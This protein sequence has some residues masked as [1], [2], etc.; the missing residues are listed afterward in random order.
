MSNVINNSVSALIA[1]QRAI[2]VASQN[3][4]NA[5]TDGYVRQRID[6]STQFA[7][8][9]R[10][11]L[12]TGGVKIDGVRR[13]VN[14]FLI[15]QARTAAAGAGRAEVMAEQASAVSALLSSTAI[16]PDDALQDLK[17]AFNA[18]ATEPGSTRARDTLLTEIDS[19][20]DKFQTVDTRL[21]ALD[22]GINDRL[23]NEADEVNLLLSQVAT[24]NDKLF[25]SNITTGASPSH[26]LDERDRLLDKLSFKLGITVTTVANDSVTVKTQDGK[27]LVQG[28][29]A[30]SLS[31]ISGLHDPT[32]MRVSLLSADGV[33]FD[34]TQQLAGGMLGGLIDSRSQVTTLVR[35][36]LGRVAV[37][38]SQALNAQ[39]RAGAD[40]DGLTGAAGSDVLAVGAPAV[41]KRSTNSDP[42]ATLS[43]AIA[44]P[45]LLSSADYLLTKTTG[46]WEVKRADSGVVVAT[47][48]A[49]TSGSPLVFEGLQ[50]SLAS[51]TLSTGD[52][53]LIRPTHEALA[54][55]DRAIDNPR[56]LAARE[57]SSVGVGDNKNA[58]ELLGVF[59]RRV[60][61]DSK[62]SV[63]E[64]T[65]RLANKV[66]AQA[67]SAE[68]SH[69][70]QKLAV[71]E[72]NRQRSDIFGVSLD[73]E[74]ANLMRYQQAYQASASVIRAANELFDALLGA[75]N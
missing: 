59:D 12:S 1:Y 44:N 51:G 63:L 66:G 40:L 19:F 52:S 5:N 24:L 41:F 53:F 61:E 56:E 8:V 39:N 30:A 42:T 48:G 10:V 31:I 50:V 4:A 7:P 34:Q 45:N 27:L 68:L 55:L 65:A 28:G 6:L 13:E 62:T 71:D 11:G 9:D 18:L 67:R 15:E 2:D 57:N 14:S 64:A 3:I 58:L 32:D 33:T 38:L 54:G 75:V 60:L 74:A 26:I 37:G 16:G 29:A 35:N 36:E 72:A 69:D 20:V 73:E 47:T 23:V 22:K 25:R 46:G 17:N 21:R 43:A 70:I 49:G